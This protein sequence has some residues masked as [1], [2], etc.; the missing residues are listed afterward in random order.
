MNR[1][2]LFWFALVPS[3]LIANTPGKII[4][5]LTDICWECLFP[6]TVSGVNITSNVKPF[7][8]DPTRVC[9]CAGVPPKIG[10]PFSF[11]EPLRVV[12][13]TRHAY[14]LV[15]LGGVSIGSES[16]KNR[17]SVG[18]IGESGTANSFYQVHWYKYP[19]LSLLELFT[20]FS[21]IEKG[22]MDVGYMS[23][24]DPAWNDD[25]LAAILNPE[26][27]VFSNSPAQLACIEDCTQSMASKPNDSLFWCGGCQ[28]SLYPF[29]GNVAHHTG[30]LQASSLLVHR[31]IAKL[32]RTGFAKGYQEG[33]YCEPH[34]MPIIKKSL[35]KT[36]IAYPKPQTSGSCQALGKSD[37]LWGPGKSFP[38]GGEDFVYLIWIKKQCCLDSVKASTIGG[39]L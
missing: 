28:G 13:V 21:C 11:W 14:T 31:I 6:M 18:V 22:D 23:E 5:P 33:D 37:L 32:H 17:G 4:N 8:K 2:F 34:Y 29:T 25:Q 7:S 12:D 26:S 39:A 1:V 9:I 3:L 24:L 36:Q 16:V 19:I 38:Y 20:D 35:Y 15:G 27:V 10:I 30:A